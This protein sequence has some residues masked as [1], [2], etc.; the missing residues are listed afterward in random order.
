MNSPI[1]CSPS[2]SDKPSRRS[3]SRTSGTSCDEGSAKTSK[4]SA[5]RSICAEM[6]R[7]DAWSD[8]VAHQAAPGALHLRVRFAMIGEKSIGRDRTSTA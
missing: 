2:I 7:M 6:A 4:P 3:I 5:S 1:F 8:T